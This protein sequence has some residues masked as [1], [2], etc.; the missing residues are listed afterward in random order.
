M[1]LP[2][3]CGGW[4]ASI[5]SRRQVALPGSGAI[6]ELV[7]EVAVQRLLVVVA[8]LDS[9]GLGEPYILDQLAPA[10]ELALR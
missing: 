10:L 7:D 1:N 6:T 2:P 3:S 9:Q 8:R 4:V 5:E